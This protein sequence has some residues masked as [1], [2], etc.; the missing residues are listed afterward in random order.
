MKYAG[1]P[2]VADGLALSPPSLGR[3][4]RIDLRFVASCCA[5]AID[6]VTEGRE[7]TVGAGC[8]TAVTGFA[9][10]VGDGLF[11]FFC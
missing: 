4:S 2:D 11:T 6:C 8:V 9:V 7:E 3:D 1:L 10:L 5:G